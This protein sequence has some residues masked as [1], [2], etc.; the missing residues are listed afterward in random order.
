MTKRRIVVVAL[1]ALA[2]LTLVWYVQTRPGRTLYVGGPILTMDA[3]NRVVDAL[4]VAGERIA[5]V[6]SE[7]ELREWARREGAR[8]VDSNSVVLAALVARDGGELLAHE[9]LPDREEI[10]RDALAP[11]R[12]DVLLVSGGSS[13]GKEDHAPRLVAELGR[14][15]FHGIA[16]RPSS[17][18][19]VGRL[20]ALDGARERLVFLLEQNNFAAKPLFRQIQAKL[21]PAPELAVVGE[22]IARFDAGGAKES[23]LQLA[24]SQGIE[25]GKGAA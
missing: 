8:I 12:A 22:K 19:G 17:P 2:V 4:A 13:V 20:P 5:G 7:A 14:L 21:G 6:G 3:D 11:A 24:A 15:D 23:L 1:V 9:I 18:A 25:L 10:V 16:M